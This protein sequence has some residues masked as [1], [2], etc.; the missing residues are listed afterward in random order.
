MNQF[1]R[2][3]AAGLL[4]LTAAC[5]QNSPA[6]RTVL[7]EPP[8]AQRIQSELAAL[9]EHYPPTLRTVLSLDP[10]L[11]ENQTY[12]APY[13]ALESFL[14]T[15]PEV[16]HNPA[17]YFGD[18]GA[19]RF[20][21]DSS[22]VWREVLGGLGIFAGFGMAISLLVWLIRTLVDFRRWSRLSRVQT[23]VHNK[24]LDRFTAN[25]DLLAY[26]QSP[27]GS[28]F[29]ESSPIALDAAPRHVGAPMSR[30]LWSVQGG[31]VLI[32]AGIG[33]QVVSGRVTDSSSQPLSGLGVLAIAL[34]L[35]FVVSAILSF[36]ISHRMGLIETT[37]P[38][39]T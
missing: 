7:P 31:V 28:K 29:L 6:P 13:P 38:A 14:N 2:F 18:G 26:I 10:T 15:H 12:L 4:T 24:L 27:A 25:D 39:G 9:M 17:F 32:A 36:V 19:P 35:G 20:R 8:D 34:G 23:E 30:I 16:L 22:E 1:Q 33:L 3:L 37:P 11:L 21:P 5:A